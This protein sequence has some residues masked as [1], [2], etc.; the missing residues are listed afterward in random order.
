MK[1]NQLQN[2]MVVAE[3]GSV[4][5]ASHRLNLSQPAVSKSIKQLEE[6][7]GARLLQRGPRGVVATPTGD[8]LIRRARIIA[9]EIDRARREVEFMEG[10]TGGEISIGVTQT[11]TTNLLPRAVLRFAKRRPKVRIY[12]EEDN[13][14]EVLAAVALGTFDF[15]VCFLPGA[16]DDPDLRTETLIEESFIPAVRSGHPLVKRRRLGLRDLLSEDWVVFGRGEGRRL[17]FEETF[18]RARLS[19]PD[20]AI[21][22]NSIG[23]T[24]SMVEASNRIALLPS[25]ILSTGRISQALTPLRLKEKPPRWTIGM[26]TRAGGIL[27]PVCRELAA[28]IRAQVA[29]H[30]RE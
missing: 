29:E 26:V 9:S 8:A 13:L 4:R 11:V 18:A 23:C 2:L 22:S 27:P 20:S 25:Q 17:V 21:E 28:D 6:S 19:P 24:V 14:S 5:Q 16:I 1:F 3:T 30:P 10:A 7:V 12:I 15:A